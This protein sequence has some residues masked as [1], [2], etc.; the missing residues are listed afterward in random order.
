MSNPILE[1][2]S[3]FSCTKEKFDEF[4]NNV[5]NMPRANFKELSDSIKLLKSL[6]SYVFL[7]DSKIINN[8]INY[9]TIYKE[10]F[11]NYK[12]GIVPKNNRNL[13]FEKR[14]LDR[15]ENFNDL[16]DDKG[17]NGRMFRHYMEYL[18]FFGIIKHSVGRKKKIDIDSLRELILTPE[19][20]LLDVFRNKLLTLNINSN[21][22]IKSIKGINVNQNADYRPAHAI[23]SYCNQ[24]NRPATDFEISILLGRI[25]DLQT[26]K[27]IL[28]RAL[29]IGNVLPRCI[30]DQKKH[31]FGC[32]NW[33]NSG[34]L[35]H[36]AQ[37]Q[38]PEF[39]FKTFL[40]FMDTFGLINYN[41]TT[42]NITLTEYSK[43]LTS[44]DVDFEILDLDKLLM[45]IDDDSED[46]NKLA[47][48]IIRKRTKTIIQAIKED[49]E[50][51]TK[52]NLRS[53]RNPI[54]KNNR[55]Q[56]SRLIAEIAKIKANYL[57]ELT[58][59]PSFEDKYGRNYVEAHHIIEFNAENGPDITENLICLGP[60]NH[61]LVHHG[62]TNALSDFYMTCQTRGIITFERFKNICIKYHCLTKEHVKI[63]LEKK[64]I[65]TIDAKEL[66]QLIDD[67]GVDPIF[68][69]SLNFST[70]NHL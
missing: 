60:Q 1:F 9:K 61:S 11:I 58:K 40:L 8:P 45:M 69:N 12:K 68:L 41:K 32:M 4:H 3:S 34:G 62:S 46:S 63:L 70:N 49:G 18:S 13:D 19:N 31:F 43:S 10:I 44:E 66:N 14:Y 57:D 30:E 38:S 5:I 67:N 50:L 15:N 23:I 28:M 55:R 20:V 24:I 35:F 54:I 22:F 27:A 6:A 53:I 64:I 39:K 47:D 36:Y 48:I 26:E 25:D 65:S 37:S 2:F 51:V 17:K 16:Y 33:K 29:A 21:D 56:R 7:I 42:K 52:L 59:T